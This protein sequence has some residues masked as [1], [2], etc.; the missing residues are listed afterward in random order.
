MAEESFSTNPAV[1]PVP[2]G[3]RPGLW[4]GDE[5][6]NPNYRVN[7]N[8]GTYIR[9]TPQGEAV[10]MHHD[11]PGVF[12]NEVDR[13]VSPTAAAAAGYDTES[14]LR[15]RRRNEARNA[16]VAQV[17]AEYNFTNPRKVI[18][19]RGEYRVIELREGYYNVE[20]LDGTVMN[21]KGPVNFDL[22]MKIFRQSLN[23]PEPMNE[24]AATKK[25][26]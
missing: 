22:A 10:Y 14:L 23:E 8:R 5:K 15:I 19:E 17:D 6:P 9:Y 16:A 21:A 13:I 20:F 25:V 3:F 1:G 7:V 24:P 11:E 18:E 26:R 2:A 12:R 4:A